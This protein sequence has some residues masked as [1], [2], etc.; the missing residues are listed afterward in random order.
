MTQKE[1]I[2]FF[3]AQLR[4]GFV[5][6]NTLAHIDSNMRPV[7]QAYANIL[8]ANLTEDPAEKLR[9]EWN[10]KQ[11]AKLRARRVTGARSRYT[12]GAYRSIR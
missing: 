9:R 12:S 5:P 7:V 1:T 2:N 6:K 11:I 8:N 10:A 4:Y 3:R